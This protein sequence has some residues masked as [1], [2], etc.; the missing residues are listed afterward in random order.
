MGEICPGPNMITFVR[1]PVKCETVLPV[2]TSL[3]WNKYSIPGISV[4]CDFFRK[5]ATTV[6]SLRLTQAQ[7]FAVGWA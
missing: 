1:Y 7:G 4:E 5:L 6:D 2:K 3:T